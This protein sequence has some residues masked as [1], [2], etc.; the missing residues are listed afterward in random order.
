MHAEDTR[1][2]ADICFL[3]GVFDDDVAR[4]MACQRGKRCQS[5]YEEIIV[6]SSYNSDRG[7]QYTSN[8]F[9]QRIIKAGMT[10]SM[11]RVA[12]CIDNGPMEGF[13]GLMKRK[14]YYTR[15]YQTKDELMKAIH[16]YI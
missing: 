12:R 6:V 5:P 11:S 7:Y 10:Q 2:F 1:I 4:C 13:W 3:K 8:D 15:K 16:S 14:M 9:R